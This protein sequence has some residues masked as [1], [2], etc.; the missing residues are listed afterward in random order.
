ME[1][2]DVIRCSNDGP[3]APSAATWDSLLLVLLYS[4]RPLPAL[5]PGIRYSLSF[6]TAIS[7]FQPYSS[8]VFHPKHFGGCYCPVS[9]I[10]SSL[11][12]LTP[13]FSRHLHHLLEEG[14]LLP[15][16]DL[17]P[18]PPLA[19]WSVF[20]AHLGNEGQVL[21]LAPPSLPSVV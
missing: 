7:H 3:Y 2:E 19:N 21:V 4:H 13:S 5:L 18:P 8:A 12:F 10:L 11:A 15:T 1:P 16:P 14:F 9:L 17:Q 6:S 20:W